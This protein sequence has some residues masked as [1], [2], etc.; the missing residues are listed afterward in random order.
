MGSFGRSAIG[1]ALQNS[2]RGTAVELFYWSSRNREVDFVLSLEGA[3]VAI[4]AKSGRRKG[5]FPGVEA[6]SKEFE[7][8]RKL[9]VGPQGM[10]IK[11]F[12]LTPP[13]DWF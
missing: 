5:S 3:L 4:E 6:F 9:L 10:P 2:I 1:A 7:L 13:E 8:K 11:E 12:L